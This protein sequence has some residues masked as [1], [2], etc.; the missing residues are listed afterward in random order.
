MTA[1][2]G[3]VSAGGAGAGGA[4]GTSAG[5]S[6]GTGGTA[7]AGG[8]AVDVLD[9]GADSPDGNFQDA[10]TGALDGSRWS[11]WNAFFPLASGSTNN[12]D[13]GTTEDVSGHDYS[14]SYGSGVTF[15]NSAMVLS[16]SGN[17]AISPKATVPVVDLT[18]SYSVSVWLKM[19][20]TSDYRTFVS[21]DG[22]QVS[23]FYL[24]KRADTGYFAFTL[25]TSDSNDGVVKPCVASASS[26]PDY[27]ALYHLVATRDATTGLDTLYVNGVVAGTA[28]CLASDGVGWAA[29]TFGIGHGMYN[30]AVTDYFSGSISGVGLLSRALTS[31]EVAALYALG[32]G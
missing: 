24:Q 26:V 16:G 10:G 15:S 23:E 11:D 17:V 8:T 25:S 31:A 9:S 5:G 7:G 1:S 3:T 22:S 28:T 12:G 30:G 20:D 13:P 32:P 18:G 6:S 14:A 4:T 19:T 21:A 27:G 29:D 2:G